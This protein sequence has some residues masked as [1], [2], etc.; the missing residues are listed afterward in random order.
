MNQQAL[1]EIQ[2]AVVGGR[3]RHQAS[4]IA[5]TLGLLDLRQAGRHLGEH[6]EAPEA[7]APGN[8]VGKTLD[9][10]VT[11]EVDECHGALSQL[12]WS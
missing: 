5:W 3:G 2:P 11:V 1:D 9:H 7:D 4:G 12:R 10:L 8:R 6:V